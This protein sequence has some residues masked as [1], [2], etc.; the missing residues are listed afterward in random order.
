MDVD[1]LKIIT[2]IILAVLGWI[3]G[4]FFT[5]RRDKK[6]KKRELSLQYLVEAYRVLTNDVSERNATSER[7]EKLENLIS[8]IQLFGTIE[9]VELSRKLAADAA[10]SYANGEAFD[11]DP[12]INC[13]RDNLRRELGLKPVKENV[14]WFRAP[15][16]E[17]N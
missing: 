1:Y 11:L 7:V 8:D 15:Q 17:Y 13:L 9:Q 12:L 6:I 16:E 10:K 4:H 3:V 2:T 5:S 14:T